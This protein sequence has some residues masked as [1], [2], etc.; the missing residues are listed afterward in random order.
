MYNK[1]P[2]MYRKGN[3]MK[4][5]FIA[6]ILVVA[7]AAFADYNKALELYQKGQFKDSLAVVA[8]ELVTG[9]DA[10]PGSPNY[11]M[12]YLAA[13]N[14]WKL[15]NFDN[16]A[17]HLRK[18]ALINKTTA[19]PYIDLALLY[20]DQKKY[21][22]AEAYAHQ[23]IALKADEPMGYLIM[24]RLAL[25]YKNYWRAKEMFEK[26]LSFDPEFYAAYNGLGIAF[27]NLG[28]YSQANTAFSAAYSIRSVSPEILSNLALSCAMMGKSDEAAMYIKKALSYK[29]DDDQIKKNAEFIAKK[30]TEGVP[31]QQ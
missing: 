13:H 30:K 10:L 18:C 22:D 3:H 2:V 31:V 29:S 16:A 21:K 15:G 23:A 12:R 27:M 19:D 25:N 17:S 6:L 9:N 5:L 20:L 11:N 4:K 24:G 1:E 7:T 28:K 26:A 8:A 14:H